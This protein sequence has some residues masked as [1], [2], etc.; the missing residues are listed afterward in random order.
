MKF[1]PTSDLKTY[2]STADYT[3]HEVD[4][5]YSFVTSKTVGNNLP[6]T[7]FKLEDKPCLDSKDM[8]V[9]A[10]RQFY[11]LE[12]DNRYNGC[13]TVQQFNEKFD[14]RYTDLGLKIS[15][16]DVQKESGVLKALEQLPNYGIY[17]TDYTKK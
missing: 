14:T 12:V 8:S 5:E 16:Y 17:A 11:P 9:A 15:E 7:S 2:N 4:D 3:V 10:N 1:V 13:Q 6:I